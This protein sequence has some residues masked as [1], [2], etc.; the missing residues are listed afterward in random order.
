MS[1]TKVFA[2]YVALFP[3]IEPA[4]S[5]NT[6][7]DLES[8][9]YDNILVHH[10][11]GG[12]VPEPALAGGSTLGDHKLAEL[13]RLDRPC[14][15]LSQPASETHEA[16]M[17]QHSQPLAANRRTLNSGRLPAAESPGHAFLRGT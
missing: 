17:Q 15:L 9:G 13:A 11:F 16:Q 6:W 2:A 5:M 7:Q 10:A 1:R 4:L 14:G 8:A 3:G 12:D